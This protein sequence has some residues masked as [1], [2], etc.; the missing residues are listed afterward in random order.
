VSLSFVSSEINRGQKMVYN[1]MKKT[2]PITDLINNIDK[3]EGE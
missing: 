3:L 2:A 1:E